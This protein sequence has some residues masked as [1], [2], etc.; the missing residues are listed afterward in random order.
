MAPGKSADQ[1]KEETNMSTTY[2][3][4][5]ISGD[6]IT[7]ADVQRIIL[8]AK[9]APN[10]YNPADYTYTN[11]TKGVLV[12]DSSG[13]NPMALTLLRKAAEKDG[14]PESKLTIS[15]AD[16]ASNLVLADG[17]PY[18]VTI[19]MTPE[20]V[21]QLLSAG[22]FLYGFKVVQT[23]HAGSPVVWFKT[24]EFSAATAVNWEEQ[25]QAY[26]SRSQIIP[27]GKIVASFAA[28]IILGQTLKVSAGGVGTVTDGVIPTAISIL[29]TVPFTCGI[30]QLFGAVYTPLCAFPLFGNNQDVIA[31]IEK[32]FLMFSTQPVNTGTVIE[33]SYGP[34]ILIDLTSLNQRAVNYDINEGWSWGGFSWANQYP[35]NSDL[36]PLLIEPATPAPGRVSLVFEAA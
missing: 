10:Q 11:R 29:N 8:N 20:T 27:G 26:T 33:Q 36:V 1:K 3:F 22:F 23:N 25:Y 13:D 15:S 18:V 19:N 31:P 9:K 34:G 17:T 12:T 4:V 32:V 30:S 5:T 6:V 28:D 24:Q 16:S 35:P 14:F 7:I 21:T 2:D